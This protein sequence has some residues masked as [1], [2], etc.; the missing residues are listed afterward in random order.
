MR[1]ELVCSLMIQLLS[2]SYLLQFS[3]TSNKKEILCFLFDTVP[4]IEMVIEASQTSILLFSFRSSNLF[5]IF[6]NENC[7]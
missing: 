3:E 6:V 4:T 1:S 7:L 2:G 5:P